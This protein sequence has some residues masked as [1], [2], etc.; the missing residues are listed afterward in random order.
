MKKTIISFTILFNSIIAL[1][2]I[3]TDDQKS[4]EEFYKATKKWFSA[5][6]IISK[7]RYHIRKVKPVEF[8]FFD[9]K[10]VYS[11]SNIT[12]TNGNTI[13]G[14]N[15]LN[16]KLNWKKAPHNG[17]LTMPDKATI[18]I[19][20]MS[21]VAEIPQE[22]NKSFFAM[23]LPSFWVKSGVVSKE[24]GL[25][26]LITGVFIHEFSHSQQMQNFGKQITLYEQENT[27]GDDFNDDI[28]Q[29][30]FQDNSSYVKIYNQE[31]SLLYSAIQNNSLDKPFLNKAIELMKR[32]QKEYFKG[33]YKE[34][35][36]ID[37]FFLTM[38]GLGQYSMYLWLIHPQG[39]NIKKEI[40]I[41][42]VRR[43]G[44]WW[45]QEEGL[46]LFLVLD[47]VSKSK[48]WAKEMFGNKTISV[49]ALIEQYAN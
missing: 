17:T 27:F 24:L 48:K 31:V 33:E 29:N 11:T 16:L 1:G 38:E 47:N 41:I 22:T 40:A 4:E 49:T 15:L 28:V 21:F 36:T 19:G 20:L 37:N 25:E 32:R 18:P 42:G 39:G 2:Q 12:I 5:W 46:A 45:S 34:L 7:D 35:S 10:Y 43:G 6:E 44:K 30:I 14:C 8:V 3:K 9:E 23:P 26:N 13:K